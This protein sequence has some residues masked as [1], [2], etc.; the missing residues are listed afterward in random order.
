V[1]GGDPG[2]AG[3]CGVVP[4]ALSIPANTHSTDLE[5]P[6]PADLSK[7][8]VMT[9]AWRRA[10]Y[11]EPV[12]KA[13]AAAEGSSELARFV[14]SLGRTDR[15]QRQATLIDRLRPRFG[16][17]LE[18]LNQSDAAMAVNGP[19][20]AI[21]EAANHV[22]ADPAVDFLVFGEEDVLVS[23]DVLHYMAQ[24][25]G[26]FSGDEKVLA[27]LAHSRCGQGWDGPEVTDDPGAD[28][29]VVRLAPYFNPWC[30]GTWRDRWEKVLEP[31]WDWK[32]DSGG[33][34]TSGYD[35]CIQTKIIPKGD[36]VCVV[37]AASRSQNIGKLEGWA[38]TPQSWAFSQARSFCQKRETGYTLEVAPCLS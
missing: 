31:M 29:S 25:A 11:L 34:M 27:V 18:I 10:Y 20:T 4:A 35:W 37:P 30:F 1:A 15:Y 36:Y 23:A 7:V 8:A 32:C 33:A 5:P 12:L 26:M 2:E 9:T 3:A 14:I 28:P 16:V 6:V 22:F 24:A 13:W 21:A 19:H 38:T 17:P